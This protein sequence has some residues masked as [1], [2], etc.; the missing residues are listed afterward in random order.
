LTAIKSAITT[1]C[2]TLRLLNEYNGLISQ[3]IELFTLQ[4]STA[5]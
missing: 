4:T 3:P 2:E 5:R 1:V